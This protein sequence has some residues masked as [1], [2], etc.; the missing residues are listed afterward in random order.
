MPAGYFSWGEALM[1]H[2]DYKGALSKF[3]LANVKGPH[4]AEPLKRWGDA[5]VAV[6][7]SDLALAK[8]EESSR[9]A[10]RWG[11]LYIA[12]GRALD[13]TGRHDE[14]V[15]NYRAALTMELTGDEHWGLRGCCG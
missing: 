5:L 9:Y 3:A 1:R 14:A 2:H 8:Y 7:R 6:R 13:Y 12:W 15:A 11:G 10:P 4:W